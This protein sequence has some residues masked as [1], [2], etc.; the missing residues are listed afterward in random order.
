M[1]RRWNVRPEGSNW[2]DFGDDDELGRLNLLTPERRVKAA[3]E[4][5]A[6]E[7]FC[8]SLPLDFPGG[9]VL[10]PN[11]RPPVR[12][13]H[14]RKEGHSS[15][16]F[17]FS[18]VDPCLVDCSCDDAVTLFTQ[19]STQWDAL[20]HMG[21]SFDAAGNGRP[22]AM[23]YNGF[24]AESEVFGPDATGTADSSRL[25]IEKMAETGVQGRGVLLDLHAHFGDARRYI[26]YSELRSVI[27]ADRVTI[28]EGDMLC[29]HTGF[30]QKI[31]GMNGDPDGEVLRNSCAVLDGRDPALLQWIADSGIS[32]LIADNFA[33]EGFPYER[34]STGRQ[35]HCEALPLHQACL[36]R[37]GIHLGELWYLTRLADWLR[38]HGRH[39]F[40]LTCPPLRL[41]GAFGSPLTPVATV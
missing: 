3:R 27:E 37:L 38:A 1:A 34:H 10:N 26:G 29:L 30:A 14:A 24:R 25:G 39:H 40:M 15:A 11:R 21:Q 32:V 16:N 23:Y 2:G 41:R 4:V 33:V 17:P 5:R 20:S 36:F 22:E 7:V 35:E 12:H 9:T 6:G 31:M 13:V 19:Y 8:L 28:E 18:T